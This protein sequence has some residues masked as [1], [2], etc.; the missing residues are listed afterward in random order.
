MRGSKG[1]KDVQ[2]EPRIG[3]ELRGERR[4]ALGEAEG[5]QETATG[6]E[7]AACLR[8]AGS[9]GGGCLGP[10]VS[11]D[12]LGEADDRIAARVAP[13]EQR[14]EQEQQRYNGKQEGAEL[15]HG[16]AG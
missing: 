15:G 13:K 10:A 16:D 5:D 11:G 6:G 9:S 8:Q 3:A 4:R 2:K 12:P 1:T 14:D 7:G